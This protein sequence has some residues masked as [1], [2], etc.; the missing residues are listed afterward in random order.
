VSERGADTG[1]KSILANRKFMSILVA[2]LLISIGTIGYILATSSL[3]SSESLAKIEVGDAVYVNYVGYFADHPGDWVFDTN[4]R[5]VAIDENIVK[6][7]YFVTRDPKEYKPLNFTAGISENYLKS[8]VDG[9]VGMTVTQTKKIFIPAEE[10]YP[11]ALNQIRV[12]DLN[13]ISPVIYEMNKTDFQQLYTDEPAIGLTVEHYFWEWDTVVLD[14][15]GD[16]VIMQNEPYLGQIVSSFGDPGD[17]PRDGWYQE[18]V[19]IDP[20]ADGGL[21]RITV[22]NLITAQDIYQKMGADYDKR[23]FTLLFV[24]ETNETFSII[25]NDSGYIGEL[26][27]RGL[28]FDITV[29]RVLKG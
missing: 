28:Y 2:L 1:G 9:V 6:S 3:V 15:S 11:L 26:A 10:G 17:D 13:M 5:N 8:F 20:G 24:D 23:K 14:I 12:N 4:I 25:M 29:T 19:S 21:G 7:L 22:H 16:K 18:V 27:G